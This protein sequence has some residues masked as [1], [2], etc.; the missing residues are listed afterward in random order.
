VRGITDLYSTIRARLRRHH[1]R[2]EQAGRPSRTVDI[3]LEIT[4]GPEVYVERINITGNTRSEDRILRRELPFVEGDLFTLQKLQRAK[5][6][7]DQPR[8]LRDG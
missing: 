1:P 8:L 7:P 5:Q 4:E 2:T 3:T 6:R